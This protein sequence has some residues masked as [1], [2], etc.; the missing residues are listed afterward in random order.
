MNQ[1]E[2][3]L[4]VV[5]CGGSAFSLLITPQLRAY[6]RI[7]V[8]IAFFALTAVALGFDWCT[9]RV[10]GSGVSRHLAA[11][12]V[13]A[14]VLLGGTWD[15]TGP[16]FIPAYQDVRQKFQADAKFFQ[17]I[18][19]RLPSG[20]SVFQLP[21]VRFP[22][23]PPVHHMLDYDHLRGYLHTRS[24]RWSYGA[25]KGREGDAWQKSLA[26]LPAQE[27]ARRVALAGF[28]GIYLNRD[29]YAD[30]GAAV[31]KAL[32][33]ELNVVPVASVDHRL[34]FFDIT[35]YAARMRRQS[36]AEPVDKLELLAN[37]PELQ[38]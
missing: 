36:M 26:G 30:D 20:S 6:N 25:L 33:E 8:Y 13:W 1:G 29:G 7:C 34:L 3:R 28:S 32:I 5:G 27:L 37:A 35:E 16:R 12:V 22:E 10:G 24:L 15:Q 31:E 11:V 38:R 4:A 14:L 9:R 19:S 21:V 18:E 17:A 23:E 2:I